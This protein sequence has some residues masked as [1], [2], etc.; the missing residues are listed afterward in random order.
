M[1]TVRK[2][3]NY[4]DNKKFQEE[5][6]KYHL[7]VRQC[8][9]DNVQSPRAND[10][11][12]SCIYLIANRYATKPNFFGYSWLSEMISDGI[13][14]SIKYGLNKY[15][16]TRF[17]NPIAYFTE[18]IHFSFVRRINTEKREQYNKLKLQQNV[19]LIQQL[20]NNKYIPGSTNETNDI[21]IKDFEDKLKAK[22]E[23]KSQKNKK[24]L[25]KF[26]EE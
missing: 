13:E 1:K 25:E 5:M 12:G 21:L 17:S 26:I 4:I 22:S 24:G 18:I 14:N 23:I 3:K 16:P 11:I 19:N 8:Q 15:D 9:K 20:D 10:Y 7:L 6:L 2:K